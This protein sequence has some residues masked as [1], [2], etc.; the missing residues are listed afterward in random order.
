MSKYTPTNTKEIKGI[1]ASSCIDWEQYGMNKMNKE[2]RIIQ[3]I[4]PARKYGGIV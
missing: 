3:T 4:L 2:I 1:K